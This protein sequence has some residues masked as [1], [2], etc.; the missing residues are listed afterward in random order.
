MA[1]CLS[2]LA[3]AVATARFRRAS[4]WTTA[5][6]LFRSLGNALAG[7]PDMTSASINPGVGDACA[8]P[9]P[10][11]RQLPD[12]RKARSIGIRQIA[13][14]YAEL[15]GQA[16]GVAKL[17]ALKSYHRARHRANNS[18]SRGTRRA[19]EMAIH[20]WNSA[21]DLKREHPVRALAI[22]AGMAFLLGAAS[23]MWRSQSL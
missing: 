5:H 11:N 14:M 3:I 20:T 16:M 22:V 12:G 17:S 6:L 10:P 7:E 8:L 19:Q 15:A 13:Q 9:A 18:Y 4:H 2:A 23:R 1:I 21:S